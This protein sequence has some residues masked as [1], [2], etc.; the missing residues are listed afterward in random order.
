[1]NDTQTPVAWIAIRHPSTTK[2]VISSVSLAKHYLID[3]GFL[4]SEI[5]PLYIAQGAEPT[6]WST[7]GGENAVYISNVHKARDPHMYRAFCVP[8][9]E[10][11]LV[12]KQPDGPVLRTEWEALIAERDSLRRQL[13]ESRHEADAVFA[14]W[15]SCIARKEEAEGRLAPAPEGDTIGR[16]PGCTS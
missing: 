2:S 9:Y 15:N 16:I 8:L 6:V 13:T 12:A 5:E 3:E 11:P 1:M 7:I 4:D 10:V 14:G